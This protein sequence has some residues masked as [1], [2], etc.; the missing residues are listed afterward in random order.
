MTQAEA[1]DECC[2]IARE[3]ALISSACAGMTF[4]IHP[5]TQKSMGEWEKI[6]YM[7]GLG[8]HPDTLARERAEKGSP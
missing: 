7:H 2:R 3:H 5:E 1:Y 8:K 4:I 6:Q